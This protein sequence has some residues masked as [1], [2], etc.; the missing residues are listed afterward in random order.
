MLID[1]LIK[2]L[3]KRK[4]AIKSQS[5]DLKEPNFIIYARHE[6]MV[7]CTREVSN[8][9][10]GFEP[11]VS[12]TFYSEVRGYPVYHVISDEAPDYTIVEVKAND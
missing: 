1:N 11:G 9:L 8:T 12:C 7:E 5:A 3:L 10:I 6:F 2:D 4:Y